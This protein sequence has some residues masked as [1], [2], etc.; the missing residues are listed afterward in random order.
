MTINACLSTIESIKQNKQAEQKQ[1]HTYRERFNGC[2]MGGTSGR[3]MKKGE[4]I[5]KYKLVVTE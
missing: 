5:N 4:V 2:Q 1:N 3:W